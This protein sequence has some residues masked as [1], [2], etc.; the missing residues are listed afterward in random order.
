[1]QVK[2]PGSLKGSGKSDSGCLTSQMPLPRVP[3]QYP[4][5]ADPCKVYSMMVLG[6][7]YQKQF[8]LSLQPD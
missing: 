4:S 5:S 3:F 7:E 2:A 6:L 1:M 8:N